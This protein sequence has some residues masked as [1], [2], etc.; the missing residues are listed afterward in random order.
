[1]SPTIIAAN[2]RC[3][4]NYRR[5]QSYHSWFRRSEKYK[6]FWWYVA[7]SK[8]QAAAGRRC[9]TGAASSIM[10]DA[11][12]RGAV[13]AALT[14]VVSPVPKFRICRWEKLLPFEVETLCEETAVRI[15][16]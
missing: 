10:T 16:Q 3:M 2:R 6:S 15:A 11:G 1:M 8:A 13:H 9:L 4:G 12:A 7:I 5:R 14:L